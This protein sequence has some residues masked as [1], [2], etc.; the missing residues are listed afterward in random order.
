[1]THDTLLE[2]GAATGLRSEV[3]ALTELDAQARARHEVQ[4]AGEKAAFRTARE[5]ELERQI[6]QMRAWFAAH[7]AV[8]GAMMRP[9]TDIDRE[10]LT[11]HMNKQRGT[12]ER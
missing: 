2:A 10:H 11:S 1:M 5:A 9:F 8:N 4:R 3:A 7:R 12:H 6:E